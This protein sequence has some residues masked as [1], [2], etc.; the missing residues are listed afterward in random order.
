MVDSQARNKR[1]PDQSSGG[2]GAERDAVISTPY[3]QRQICPLPPRKMGDGDPSVGGG[4]RDHQSQ[5]S[6]HGRSG[7]IKPA[8]SPN[9]RGP[10]GA[11][12]KTAVQTSVAGLHL[13]RCGSFQPVGISS[14]HH[15]F[16]GA[17]PVQ[18]PQKK[19]NIDHEQPNSSC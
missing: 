13:S 6:S 14:E 10:G 15:R 2:G 4:E 12:M 19:R 1:L 11:V 7:G 16:S 17:G 3:Q 8:T 18:P 5:Q 9:P